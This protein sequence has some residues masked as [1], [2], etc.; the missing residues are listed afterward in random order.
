MRPT[1]IYTGSQ[2]QQRRQAAEAGSSP[3]KTK[4]RAPQTRRPRVDPLGKNR[5]GA[6]ALPRRL[7]AYHFGS[8]IIW[9]TG[10][11]AIDVF[12]PILDRCGS[13]QQIMSINKRGMATH[14]T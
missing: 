13:S 14:Q 1:R 10:V 6:R 5:Y 2:R 11:I 7:Y 8:P 4:R 3:R 12:F 9:D